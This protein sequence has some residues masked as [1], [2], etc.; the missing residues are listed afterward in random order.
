VHLDPVKL[1]EFLSGEINGDTVVDFLVLSASLGE[2]R[3]GILAYVLTTTRV[4]KI[5]IDEKDSKSSSPVYLRDVLAVKRVVPGPTGSD[6]AKISV[7][8]GQ[9]SFGLSYPATNQTIDQFFRKVDEQVRGIKT[10]KA[11]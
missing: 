10:Q 11:P 7:E 2:G 5:E 1:E 4:I 3:K 9:G 6:R 8:A